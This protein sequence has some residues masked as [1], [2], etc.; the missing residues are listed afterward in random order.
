MGASGPT[1]INAIYYPPLVG[2]WWMHIGL[3]KKIDHLGSICIFNKEIDTR[4]KIHLAPC[5]RRFGK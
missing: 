4:E 5:R 3:L 2:N 1:R